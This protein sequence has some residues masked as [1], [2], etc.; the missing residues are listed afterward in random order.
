MLVGPAD[1][2]PSVLSQVVS[3][4]GEESEAGAEPMPTASGAAP[5]SGK[6]DR[7]N[8]GQRRLRA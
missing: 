2:S 5:P 1:G 4:P 8:Q 6:H 7:V 3:A